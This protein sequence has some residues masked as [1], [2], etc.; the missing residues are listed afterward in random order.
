[1][2][3]LDVDATLGGGVVGIGIHGR[4]LDLSEDRAHILGEQRSGLRTDA[5]GR[6]RRVPQR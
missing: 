2:K 3:A 5:V 1:M 4:S 6:L